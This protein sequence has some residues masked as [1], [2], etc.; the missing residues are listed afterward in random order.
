MRDVSIRAV[1]Q[2]SV[3]RLHEKIEQNLVRGRI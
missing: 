1:V 3:Q 2:G